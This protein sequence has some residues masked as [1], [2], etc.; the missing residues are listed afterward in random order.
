[1]VDRSDDIDPV[2]LEIWIADLSFGMQQS[3]SGLQEVMQSIS[4]LNDTA[5]DVIASAEIR[6]GTAPDVSHLFLAATP[7]PKE[8]SNE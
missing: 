5:C 4:R 6:R 3:L 1:M 7:T 2:D 8:Q